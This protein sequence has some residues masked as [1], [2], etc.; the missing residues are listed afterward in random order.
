MAG[1]PV[2]MIRVVSPTNPYSLGSLEHQLFGLYRDG[3]T[4]AEYMTAGG[5]RGAFY[6]D[7]QKAL[8][9]I[10]HRKIFCNSVCLVRIRARRL[11]ARVNFVRTSLAEFYQATSQSRKVAPIA[12][13]D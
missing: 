4:V 1:S 12:M 5:Q 13:R 6:R 11:T 10:A 2:M 7:L 9:Q 8:I 3:M